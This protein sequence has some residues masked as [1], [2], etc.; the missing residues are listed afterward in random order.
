MKGSLKVVELLNKALAD[1]L[2]AINQYMVHSEMCHNWGY[3]FLHKE[4]EKRAIQE[5]KH[6]EKLI[7]RI[8]FL[9]GNPIVSKLSPIKIGKNVKEMMEVD[10]KAE[11]AAVK[12]YNDFAKICVEENDNISKNLFE[13]LLKD[14]EGHVDWIENQIEQIEQMGLSVYLL[15]ATKV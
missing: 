9:E 4:I 10:L 5:M 15:K 11:E 1:E 6:A 14:E 7:E 3:D 12:D 8:L 2:A 13:E